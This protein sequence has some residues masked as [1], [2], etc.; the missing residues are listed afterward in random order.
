MLCSENEELKDR[1]RTINAKGGNVVPA[2]CAVPPTP[3]TDRVIA[4]L[5]TGTGPPARHGRTPLSP[6]THWEA[7]HE[8]TTSTPVGGGGGGGMDAPSPVRTQPTVRSFAF[9]SEMKCRPAGGDEMPA[10]DK[11]T[12]VWATAAAG[13]SPGLSS[14]KSELDANQ[15]LIE[16][17]E[18][19]MEAESE[20]RRSSVTSS[21]AQLPAASRRQ[22]RQQPP[23]PQATTQTVPTQTATPASALSLQRWASSSSNGEAAAVHAGGGGDLSLRC[24]PAAQQ[25]HFQRESV[26]TDDAAVEGS[27]AALH[28]GVASFG[29]PGDGVR[30]DGDGG[31][32]A[33]PDSARSAGTTM[34]GLEALFSPVEQAAAAQAPPPLS[35]NA[36]KAK[37][38]KTH[39]K[40][41][42]SKLQEQAGASPVRASCDIV[43]AERSVLIPSGSLPRLGPGQRV[44]RR[45]THTSTESGAAGRTW[46]TQH[47]TRG[48]AWCT[49]TSCAARITARA[50]LPWWPPTRPHPRPSACSAPA[51]C[52]R[53]R[54]R[55]RPHHRSSRRRR[56][57]LGLPARRRSG[58]CSERPCR[59]RAATAAAGRASCT[60]KF[61][62]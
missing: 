1:I 26:Q 32:Q 6:T 46:G 36:A 43:S 15:K 19:R 29:L 2:N 14:L 40:L 50:T 52:S 21:P 55:Y 22:Q 35:L 62:P 11:A 49:R 24:S 3:W 30:D 27:W 34:S 39:A 13:A 16:L 51:R 42:H 57:T 45:Q 7:P 12:P 25:L 48:C 31:G 38:Y 28:L 47:C 41:L 37:K 8:L 58:G 59:A 53:P 9:A 18:S 5:R 54:H 10:S 61:S 44:F 20:S 56:A 33:A 4:S 17:I 60:A 23:Q